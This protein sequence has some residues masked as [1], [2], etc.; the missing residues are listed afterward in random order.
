MKLTMFKKGDMLEIINI[1]A[2]VATRKRIKSLGISI[3]SHITI[4]Q[5][6]IRNNNVEI[7]TNQGLIALRESEANEIICKEIKWKIDLKLLL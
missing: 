7:Q 4:K 6:S 3:G 2:D 1:N 5:Y